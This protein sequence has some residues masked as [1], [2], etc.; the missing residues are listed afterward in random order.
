MKYLNIIYLT[1]GILEIMVGIGA[2]YYGQYL[3]IVGLFIG[4]YII[5]DA[6]NN[7]KYL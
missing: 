3:A 6:I 5:E 4:G 2:I 7:F 1:T